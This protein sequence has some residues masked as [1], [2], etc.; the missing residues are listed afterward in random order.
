[1]T[2]GRVLSLPIFLFAAE[3]FSFSV[4]YFRGIRYNE[5]VY[6]KRAAGLEAAGNFFDKNFPWALLPWKSMQRKI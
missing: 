4:E 5:I 1:M 3:K 6:T 2:I